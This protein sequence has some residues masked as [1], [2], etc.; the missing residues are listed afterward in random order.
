MESRTKHA[1]L[2]V[3]AG[4]DTRPLSRLSH[5]GYFLYVDSQP[6]LECPVDAFAESRS[7]V[8]R[9]DDA[10]KAA[11]FVLEKG[12]SD[13]RIYRSN[14]G[15]VVE[16]IMNA[17]IPRDIEKLPRRQCDV[18]IAAGHDPH[19]AAIEHCC[20][21]EGLSFVAFEG[22]VY[23]APEERDQENTVF[24]SMKTSSDFRSKFVRYELHTPYLSRAAGTWGMF[25][26]LVSF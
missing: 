11:G 1:A 16:Y 21:E 4:V 2:Y 10:M 14:D 24:A 13:V 15:R 20:K 18:L 25:N 5:I 6:S 26:C 7:F 17:N 9:V 8:D 3:G 12:T 23:C 19:V 22:T